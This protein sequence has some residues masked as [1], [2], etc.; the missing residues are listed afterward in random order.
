M[1]Y[2][3]S[4]RDNLN[5]RV[6]SDEIPDNANM[7]VETCVEI[8]NAANFTVAG[9]EFAVQCCWCSVEWK[10]ASGSLTDILFCQFVAM[11]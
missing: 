4:T 6:L 10:E 8:C 1:A 2:I 5:G 7:T 11:K 9:I 3:L